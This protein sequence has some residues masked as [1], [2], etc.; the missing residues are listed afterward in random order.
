MPEVND[1]VQVAKLIEDLSRENREAQKRVEALVEEYSKLQKK[2]DREVEH[3]RRATTHIVELLGRNS[4]K[5]TIIYKLRNERDRLEAD[6]HRA[7]NAAVEGGKEAEARRVAYLD[8][9]IMLL[10]ILDNSA[11]SDK[12]KIDILKF[13]LQDEDDD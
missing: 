4:N 6:Y 12:R 11:L 13:S 1:E 2:Y 5:Q 10:S 9:H 7:R 3:H 8:E